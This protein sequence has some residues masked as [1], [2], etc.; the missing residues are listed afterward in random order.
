MIIYVD[1]NLA[2]VLS[3]GFNLLQKPL[4]FG[5]KDPIEVKSIK[6]VFGEN[7]WAITKLLMTANLDTELTT[8]N[9]ILENGELIPDK[10][11]R[12][13]TSKEY[14]LSFS[15]FA[16]GGLLLDWA[17]ASRIVTDRLAEC[18]FLIRSRG[19]GCS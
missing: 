18:M 17:D 15:A 9:F 11:L 8:V 19:D 12:L 7:P 13:L 1:E 14:E 16:E 4:N 3:K 6:E 10:K 2:P 5:L